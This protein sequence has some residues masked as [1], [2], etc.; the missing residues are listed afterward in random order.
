MIICDGI[1]AEEREPWN[2]EFY[3]SF[4]DPLS[5]S[6]QNARRYGFIN[7]EGGNWYSQ[8]S[9]QL[10]S[11]NCDRVKIP[12]TGYVGIGKVLS[13][14]QP[15]S[16]FKSD[17]PEGEKL[18]MDVPQHGELYRQNPDNPEKSGYFVP[19]KW[20][21]ILSDVNAKLYDRFSPFLMPAI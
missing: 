15:A 8:T 12:S 11:D 3:I 13:A 10:Q 16:S 14:A 19:I 7:A 9:K 17:T 6:W 21:E 1:S 18:A 4:G 20:L 5:R 2:G